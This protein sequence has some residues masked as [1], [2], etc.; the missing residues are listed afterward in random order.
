MA[1]LGEREIETWIVGEVIVFGRE[2]DLDWIDE[3]W[4]LVCEGLCLCG[5]VFVSFLFLSGAVL[6]FGKDIRDVFRMSRNV[7]V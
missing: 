5:F 7:D 1:E 4:K 2:G 6:Y 3:R